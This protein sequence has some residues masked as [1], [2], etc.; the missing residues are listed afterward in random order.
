MS[1]KTAVT[2]TGIKASGRSPLS[3][4]KYLKI[5]MMLSFPSSPIQ[6]IEHRALDNTGIQ[7]FIKREEL[8]HPQLQGNKWRKLK[9]NIE[10]ARLQKHDT[11]LTFGGA[12][13]NHI[14]ATAAAG[15]ILGFKTIGIIR[16]ERVEPLNETLDFAEKNDMKLHF[17]SRNEYRLKNTSDF[18]DNLKIKFGD[19]YAIPE[20]GSN[21]YALQ[22]V[23]ELAGELPDDCDFVALACGTGATAA[24]L[25]QG[26]NFYKKKYKTLAFSALKNGG[27]LENDILGFLKMNKNIEN[28]NSQNV[29]FEYFKNYQFELFKNYHFGGYAKK[30]PEL[31]NFIADWHAQTNIKIEHVYTAKMLCGVF[32]LIAQNYFPQG[33]KI[34]AI[35]TGGLR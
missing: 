34:V 14:Y 32:D 1:G 3:S 6:K 10:A 16:G 19:F 21:E 4:N 23:A 22:G 24:G 28:E 29:G 33:A 8:L 9:Y 5:G 12:H 18:L 30:T 27:F 20:G 2:Y 26:R 11:L 13:S 25:I 35:H 17:I 7:L 15:H 31:Q